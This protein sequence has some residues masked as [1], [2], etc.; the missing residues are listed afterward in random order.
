MPLSF[1]DINI[2][3][4]KWLFRFA[5]ENNNPHANRISL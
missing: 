3:F 2:I 1:K 5:E 4:I